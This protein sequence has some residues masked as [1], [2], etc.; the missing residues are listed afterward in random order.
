MDEKQHGE[1]FYKFDYWITTR[2][3]RLRDLES[4]LAY[5]AAND[6]PI[7]DVMQ[8]ILILKATQ[9]GFL[10]QLLLRL[11][12]WDS[13]QVVTVKGASLF[14]RSLSFVLIILLIFF[15]MGTLAFASLVTGFELGRN[16][17]VLPSAIRTWGEKTEDP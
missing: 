4:L 13:S 5:R 10:K 11:G 12:R 6:E 15:S 1:A 3:Q 16:P 2:E 7:E 17:N 14:S 9:H 8:A